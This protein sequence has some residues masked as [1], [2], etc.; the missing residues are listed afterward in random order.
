MT[1]KNDRFAEWL[2]DHQE[3]EGCP[4]LVLA[5][6][7]PEEIV[8]AY[9]DADREVLTRCYELLSG[10]VT[11]GA[12]YLK[13][14]GEGSTDKFASMVAM[15][16]SASLNTDSTFFHGSKP[17]YEQ[18]GSQK[19]L[20]RYLKAAKK[21][22]HTPSAN[23]TYFPSLARFPG[24]PEAFVSQAQGRGYIRK[25]CEKRGWA[26]DGDV[27]VDHR[28]PESDPIAAEN[29]VDMAPDIVAGHA[30]R[31]IAQNPKNKSL[32]RAAL[33]EK[34]VSKYGPSK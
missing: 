11:R 26:C 34:I 16:K 15:Q 13:M 5:P 18:F 9:G 6:P 22:G 14:R 21:H 33:R 3:W 8:E 10:P 25:L 27:K 32:S 31:M 24:D 20:D 28:E 2:Q 1:Q 19:H 17:L 30:K 4:D 7:S 29:C 12:Q 23:D